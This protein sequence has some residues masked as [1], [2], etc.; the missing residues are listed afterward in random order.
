MWNIAFISVKNNLKKWQSAWA[1]QQDELYP[2]GIVLTLLLHEGIMIINE[3]N[4]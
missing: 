1:N 4:G 3:R 2:D